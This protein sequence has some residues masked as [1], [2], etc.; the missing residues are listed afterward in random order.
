MSPEQAVELARKVFGEPDQVQIRYAPN[1]CPRQGR[2]GTQ[3]KRCG[4]CGAQF[5]VSPWGEIPLTFRHP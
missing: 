2:V 4:L 3:L 1:T 5:T